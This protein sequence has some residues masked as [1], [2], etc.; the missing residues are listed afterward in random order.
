VFGQVFH[1]NPGILCGIGEG[2]ETVKEQT[3]A[4]RYV[5]AHGIP[6]L[7]TIEPME[8]LQ[9]RVAACLEQPQYSLFPVAPA[10]IE[11]I[12]PATRYTPNTV[13]EITP[14]NQDVP[15]HPDSQ[16]EHKPKSN[17]P[18]FNTPPPDP[19]PGGIPPEV[20]PADVQSLLSSMKP[21]QVR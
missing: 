11:N 2:T 21:P 7:K 8:S 4:I 15:V 13:D 5:F 12:D 1:L 19:F 20:N 17:V 18:K 10:E 16:P 3:F 6:P 9:A 14:R